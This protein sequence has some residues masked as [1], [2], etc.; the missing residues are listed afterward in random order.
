M[1]F[2]RSGVRLPS[3][4]PSSALRVVRAVPRY[5]NGICRASS[6]DSRNTHFIAV[7]VVWNQNSQRTA[8]QVWAR[9]GTTPRAFARFQVLLSR[10]DVDAATIATPD[11]THGEPLPPHSIAPPVAALPRNLHCTSRIVDDP[12]RRCGPFHKK[13]SL[14]PEGSRN[15]RIQ[16]GPIPSG[17][18]RLHMGKKDSPGLNTSPH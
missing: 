12:L 11:F 3:A 6:T 15:S 16:A 2:R 14:S 10:V 17:P 1:A 4:P 9:F 8:D 18:D 7:W 13:W 5:G